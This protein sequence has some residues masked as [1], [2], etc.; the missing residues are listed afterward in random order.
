MRLLK[1]I[2]ISLQAVILMTACNA[3][4][5]EFEKRYPCY[6]Y[7]DCGIHQ[8]TALQ[9]CVSPFA[10]DMFCMVWQENAGGIRH[11]KLQLYN[12]PTEDVSITTALELQR[13]CILGVKNGL[14]I[15]RSALN[16][17]E[18]YVFD[19]QCPNC[20]EI[21]SYNALQWDINGLRVK[22]PQCKRV[23][24]LNNSGFIAEGDKGKKLMRYMAS[25]TGS[26]LVVGR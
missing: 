18:L 14:I 26:L 20:L 6:M 5:Y 9:S 21:G 22:C 11:I 23:Y 3:D 19:R 13:S 15:G 8:G 2:I 24:N 1:I 25:Y 7:F 12:Q 10:V 4:D 16:N 17:S